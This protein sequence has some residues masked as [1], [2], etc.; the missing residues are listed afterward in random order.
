MRRVTLCNL[1]PKS[2]AVPSRSWF[3]STNFAT[4]ESVD[5]LGNQVYAP[6]DCVVLQDIAKGYLKVDEEFFG[7]R[8]HD[9]L[10]NEFTQRE[11]LD[12]VRFRIVR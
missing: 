9:V 6:E 5:Q 2:A 10:V 7:G 4:S 3:N 1:R 12:T 11:L 8:Y